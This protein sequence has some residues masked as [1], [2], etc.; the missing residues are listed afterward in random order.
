MFKDAFLFKCYLI[1]FLIVSLVAYLIGCVNSSILVT[2]L[3]KV[4]KDIRNVGSGNA[5]FTNVLRTMGKKMAV[6]TFLGDFLKG[7]AAVGLGQW[8]MSCFFTSSD[9]KEVFVYSSYLCCLMCVIG[10]IYPCFFGFKGGKGILTTWSAMLL[11]DWRVFLTLITVFIIVVL[12]S[13][14]VSLA[15]VIAAISYPISVFLFSCLSGYKFSCHFTL[16]FLFP[17][18]VAL[19]ISVIILIKHKS[20]ILRLLNGT[21]KRISVHK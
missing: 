4:Q 11:I 15:S 17:T 21:E 5:G 3:F 18:L 12:I 10:H 13:K 7:V 19:L 2:K 14:I 16:E 8:I 20:N 9:Y 1:P 6:I